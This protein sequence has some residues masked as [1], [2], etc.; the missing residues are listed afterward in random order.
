MAMLGRLFYIS[1][2]LLVF[3][4][5]VSVVIVILLVNP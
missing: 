1:Y 2:A 5:Q 4:P 3:H